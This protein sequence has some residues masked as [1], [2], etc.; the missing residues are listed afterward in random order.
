MKPHTLYRYLALA[1][2]LF[3]I[4][5][6]RAQTQPLSC[7]ASADSVPEI[8]AEGQT[9]RVGDFLIV[10]TGGTPTPAGQSLRAINFWLFNQPAV[11]MTSRIT[12]ANARDSM[13]EA[14][15][16][17]DEPPPAKQ[18]IC[19]SP[20]YP[21]SSPAE[22]VCE[23]PASPKGDGLGTFDP[24][25]GKGRGNAYQGRLVSRTGM[26]WYQIPFDSPGT[27]RARVLRFTNIRINASQL[28]IPMGTSASVQLLFTTAIRFL[29]FPGSDGVTNPQPVVAIARHSIQFS[30]PR[31]PDSCLACESANGAFG[32]DNTQPLASRTSCDG[33]PFIF[34]FEELFST[35][36]RSRAQETGFYKPDSDPNRWPQ[37]LAHPNNQSI[38][39]GPESRIGLADSGTRLT[40]AFTNVPDG[41][42]IW[43]P[44]ALV[45]RAG[46]EVTGLAERAG[47]DGD[48]LVLI[49]NGSGVAYFEIMRSDLARLETI[50]I[51]PVISYAA[52]VNPGVS[53]V[54]GRLGDGA[55]FR[56]ASDTAPIP[57][58]DSPTEPT[59]W[60]TIIECPTPTLLVGRV[61]QRW[62]RVPLQICTHAPRTTL[63]FHRIAALQ[64][65]T[66]ILQFF[67]VRD[68]FSPLFVG[69][70]SAFAGLLS[71]RRISLPI[72]QRVS[73][74]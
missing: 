47:S 26:M 22:L 40:L 2:P 5:A 19:G 15:L 67:G 34:R 25:S 9:E 64:R 7:A 16:L 74:A 39:A 43:L 11:D 8:R 45:I 52:S 36:F 70:A 31:K 35:A 50:D 66:T 27:G 12:F 51:E 6:L 46:A 41:V 63:R 72:F 69:Q 57:R 29:G 10:C 42:R 68:D 65:C 59:T 24:D 1:A 23:H 4:E 21:Y 14:F 61:S 17:V 62:A 73:A 54:E 37:K 32:D 30:I 55:T 56:T 13:T 44:P 60:L 71:R 33:R 28:G 3:A 48:A 20:A 49:T 58:F 53:K 38:I 18:T